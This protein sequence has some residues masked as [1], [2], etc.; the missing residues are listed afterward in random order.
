MKIEPLNNIIQ[1]E[2]EEAKAGMLDTSSRASAI[3][4][5]K[6]VGIGPEYKG[7]AKKGNM[8]FFK[9]WAVDLVTHEGKTYK[10]I[11]PDTNG[12]LAIIK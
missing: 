10:F 3:E 5:G 9:S 2:T 8:I 7:K 6:V 1:I 4:Y 12:I 11:N